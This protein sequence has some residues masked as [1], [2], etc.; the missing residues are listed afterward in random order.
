MGACTEVKKWV[1]EEV[2]KPFEKWISKAEEKC[3]EARRWVERE[4]RRPIETQRTQVQRQC[5]RRKCKW[6]CL[7]CNKW[8]C[9]LYTVILRIVE[10]IVEIVGEWLVELVCK[11]VL[12]LIKIVVEVVITVLRLIVV[13]LT[14]LF[15]EPMGALD[16]LID[17]WYD[18]VDIVGA[19]GD[20]AGDILN[21][22]SDFLD[23]ARE[24]VLDF[25]DMLGPIGRFFLGIIAGVLD[26]V[27]RVVDGARRIVDGIFDIVTG[28]LH[29]DFCQALEGLVN[30]VGFGLG[31][32]IF[33]VTGVLSLGGN[34][35][36]DGIVRDSLREWLQKQIEERFS[37]DRRGEI[38]R[39]LQM[40]SSSYGIR[41][42][43][44]PL[45]CTISSRARESSPTAT[46]VATDIYTLK[47]LHESQAINLYK[48]G[49]YAPFGCDDTPVTRSVYELVYKDTD[50]RV[51]IG[52]IRAY[53]ADGPDAA[54]EFELIAGNSRVFKDMLLVAT[55]KMR[56]MAIHLECKPLDRLEIT[57]AER[58]ITDAML[59]PLAMRI[60]SSLGLREICDL[61]AVIVFGYEPQ[62]FGLASVYWI[63]GPRMATA[64]TVRTSFMAHLFGTVLAHEMGHCFSIKHDG[65]D[66]ME[67]I[68]YTM[69]ADLD[70]VTVGTFIEYIML[71][72]EPCFTLQ[73]GKDAWTWI[74]E[75]AFECLGI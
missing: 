13:G 16:A 24:F 10:W 40:E 19:V 75:K 34:G 62:K 42:P 60:Q 64:A 67:N 39:A 45:R 58:I 49:G 59:L 26:I 46:H 32:A 23:I 41:W 22:I 31:Q 56:Q 9:W 12:K 55:R 54:P 57:R 7:C 37:G 29:L 72:G 2:R 15:T 27:R 74:L 43:V 63:D 17:F 44:Y 14:C 11:V 4:V 53:L 48:I 50:Y 68:M 65:H 69:G 47:S 18:I 5:E 33:G 30:G 28:I 1:T 35:P 6:W 70:A 52:D 3:T 51:A 71:G 20:L 36:R 38:E 21:G 61:P 73:D 66:G 25:G 8:F